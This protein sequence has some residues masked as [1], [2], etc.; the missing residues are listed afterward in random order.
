[1]VHFLIIVVIASGSGGGGV[2]LLLMVVVCL[3]DDYSVNNAYILTSL[4]RSYSFTQTMCVKQPHHN[5]KENRTDVNVI[6]CV[7]AFFPR[8]LSR[9]IIKLNLLHTE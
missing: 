9:S 8:I 5:K 4:M 1:M 2:V 3:F 7:R 6:L